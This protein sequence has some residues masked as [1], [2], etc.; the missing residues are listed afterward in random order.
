MSTTPPGGQ[1][2]DQPEQPGPG[3]TDA[4]PPGWQTSGPPPAQPSYQPGGQA[5]PPQWAPAAPAA[6]TNGKAIAALICGIAS[7]VTCLLPV[8]IVALILGYSGRKEIDASAGAQQGRGLAVAGIIM[9]W[10]AIALMV[11]GVIFFVLFFGA[12]ATTRQF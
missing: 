7:F 12:I 11:L 5:P 3:W 6:P 8:G 10:V 2:P 4:P 9:G 1:P